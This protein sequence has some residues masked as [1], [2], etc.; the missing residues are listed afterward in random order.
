MLSRYA[1]TKA[2]AA[3][4]REQEVARVSGIPP[5]G[6]IRGPDHRI[7]AVAHGRLHVLEERRADSSTRVLSAS[8]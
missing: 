2:R 5:D 8:A 4:A 1:R 7:G 6:Q 3:R